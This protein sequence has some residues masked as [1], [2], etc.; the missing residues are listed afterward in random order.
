MDV[1]EAILYHL[2]VTN[3]TFLT[4]LGFECLMVVRSNSVSSAVSVV[5][6]LVNLARD[7]C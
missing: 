2:V 7:I 5:S 1:T 3:V 4:Q 6:L